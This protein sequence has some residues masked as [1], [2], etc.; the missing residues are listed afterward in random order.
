MIS[1]IWVVIAGSFFSSILFMKYQLI[2]KKL[3][4]RKITDNCFLSSLSFVSGFL[5][6]KH[7]DEAL[8][9]QVKRQKWHHW[10]QWLWLTWNQGSANDNVD[11]FALPGEKGELGL[12]ELLWHLFGVTSD[13]LARLFD[14]YFQRLCPERLELLQSRWPDRRE[15]V[16]LS[17]EP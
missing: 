12:D 7:F 10:H 13:P 4:H 14:V 15:A 2:I 11:L 5:C 9:T 17:S 1:K 16:S 6:E 3:F 8:N